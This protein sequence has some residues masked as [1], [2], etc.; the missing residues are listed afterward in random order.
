MATIQHVYKRG[1][2]YW[3]RRRLPLGTGIH[4]WVRLEISLHTK[5][6]ERA[7]VVAPE[8]TLASHRLLPSLRH[9]MISPEDAKKILIQ[10]AKQHSFHLDAVMAAGSGAGVDAASKRSTEI[11]TGWAFRLF[12]AQGISARV[13]PDEER[14]MRAAGLDDVM[15][16]GVRET[17]AF[18]STNG[19][20]QIGRRQ[21]EA[22]LKDHNI[23]PAEAH[24]LQAEQLC[25]RGMSA[26]LL[27]TERRWSGVRPDDIALLNAAL[28]GETAASPVS[29]AAPPQAMS[30]QTSLAPFATRTVPSF[31]QPITPREKVPV[32]VRSMAVAVPPVETEEEFNLDDEDE[33]ELELHDSDKGLVEIVQQ[34][35]E[36]RVATKEWRPDMIK[37]H[38]SIARLFVRF[39]G[40]DQPARLRQRNIS[41][42]RSMLFKLPKSHGKSPN[43]HIMPLSELLARAT[44]LPPEKVGLSPTTINRYMTQMGNIVDICKHAGFPFGNF[45]GVSGLRTKRKGDVRGERGRFST[46]ELQTIFSLPVWEGSTSF[47]ERFAGGQEIFHDAAYWVP[48]LAIYIGARREEMCGLLLDEIETHFEL[49]CIRIEENSVRK[50]KNAQSKRRVP[51]HPELLRLGFLE[52]VDELRNLGH[53]LLFPELK[54]ASPTTPMGDVFDD[55]WQKIRSTALPKAKDDGKVLHSLRHWCNNEMKQ[56]GI[57]EEYRKDILGHTNEGVNEGRYTDPARLRVMADALSTLPL[58]TAHLEAHPIRPIESVLTHSSRPARTKKSVA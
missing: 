34:A 52:Y 20:G 22:I 30:Q 14:E 1:S 42:F 58:P 26:A 46:E 32:P 35:A 18:L 43:D 55:S 38:V 19:F 39:V 13:G 10:A 24:I 41:E 50:L 36:E 5:E 9:K 7:R 31:S 28:A 47:D 44:T 12:A 57:R 2:V 23:A 48:L 33:T 29:H 6:L 37:Q 15:I 3:W 4:A 17:M 54:A 25:L 49:P 40:H 8:V 21:L 16:Q 11:R 56:A 45:E 53:V 51:I 27:N